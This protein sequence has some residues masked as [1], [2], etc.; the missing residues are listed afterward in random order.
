MTTTTPGYNTRLAIYFT[1]DKNGKR[2]AYRFS[3]RQ[4]RAFPMPLADAEL[5]IAQDQADEIDGNPLH[6]KD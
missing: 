5:F 6:T 2:R 1:N 4:F 3:H